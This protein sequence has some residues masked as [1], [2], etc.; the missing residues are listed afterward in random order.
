[1]K[2]KFK[3]LLINNFLSI[4]QG[5]ISLEDKGYTLIE[6]INNNPK[7]NALSNGSGKSSIFEA[8]CF[9]LFGETSKGISSNLKN[10]NTG[11]KLEISLIINIDGDEYIVTRTEE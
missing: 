5:E 11:G 7:D 4:G 2:I 8:I 10:K 6:G 1:M 3:K 9:C